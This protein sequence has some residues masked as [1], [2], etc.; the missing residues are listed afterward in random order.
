M[1]ALFKMTQTI[2]NLK[3]IKVNL[4]EMDRK[5]DRWEQNLILSPMTKKSPAPTPKSPSTKLIK[6]P[7]TTSSP[8]KSPNKKSP[9]SPTPNKKSPT[10]KSPTKKSPPK[11]SPTKK[12][13]PKKE[14]KKKTGVNKIKKPRIFPMKRKKTIKTRGVYVI[15]LAP[16]VTEIKKV[17]FTKKKLVVVVN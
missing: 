13:P 11:K 15:T 3:D 6:S 10:K 1:F 17:N 8:K 16:P 9:S 7:K 14:Q 4:K 5:M 12:S 2:N